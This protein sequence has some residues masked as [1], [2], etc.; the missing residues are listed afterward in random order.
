MG[1]EDGRPRTGNQHLSRR[2]EDGMSVRG[3]EGKDVRQGGAGDGVLPNR[4]QLSDMNGGGWASTNG[5]TAA[6]GPSLGSA[7]RVPLVPL[8]IF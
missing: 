3:G 6:A 2:C 5:E 7:Q 4:Q 1:G 8:H